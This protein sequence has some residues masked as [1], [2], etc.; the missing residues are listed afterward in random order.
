MNKTLLALALATLSATPALSAADTA[1]APAPAA[2]AA[3]APAPKPTPLTAAEKTQA[4][5][6][7]GWF[8][9]RNLEAFGLE[10]AELELVFRGARAS[11]EGKD[12][13]E[14]QKAFVGANQARLEQFLK[15]KEE[16]NRPKIEAKS[17]ALLAEW[18]KKNKDYLAQVDKEAGVQSTASG[19]RYKILTAGT[20]PKPIS[21]SEVKALYTGKL[22]DGSVFDSTANRNNEPAKFRLDGVIPGWTEGLQKIAKGGKILLYIPAEIGYREEGSPGGIPGGATLTFEVELIDFTNE[23][24]PAPASAPAAAK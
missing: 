15:D 2:A 1:P 8:V 16:A 14:A 13:T 11:A 17:K 7:F 21:T 24:A 5:E 6:T 20:G 19:L 4:L 23:P 22:V 10:P 18:T 3:P 9:G 12:L